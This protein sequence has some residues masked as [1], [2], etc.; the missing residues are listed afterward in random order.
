MKAIF[1]LLISIV[2][3]T[4]SVIYSQST[5]DF[6][7]LDMSARAG[8]LGGSFVSNTDDANV[9]FYNP[10][11]LNFLSGSPASFSFVKHLMDINLASLAF[12]TK[13]SSIGR[14]GF[15]VRYVNYG[16]FTAADENGNKTGQYGAGEVAFIAGYSNVLSEN[17]SYGA[18]IKFIYSGIADRSSTGLALDLGLHYSMP[19]NMFDVGFAILNA[20]TQ[21]S[22]YYSTKEKLPLDI[23]VGVS[24]SLKHLPVTLSLD[25]HNLNDQQTQFFSRFKAF[26]FGAEFKLSRVLDLRLGYNNKRRTELKIGTFAGLAGFNVGLGAKIS[27]YHFDYGYSSLGLI[28]GI[29]RISV[30]T[31]L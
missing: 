19:S 8:A 27:G 1:A 17:F 15:G 14:V 12:S 11:G 29:H 13:L 10:A 24:K 2:L 16:T 21:L 31:S 4:S 3:C 23:V 18:N 7:K 22:S 26:S 5:Y 25:F 20:G 30:S 6:L 9:I 28:G